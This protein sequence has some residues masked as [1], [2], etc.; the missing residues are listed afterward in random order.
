MA[1]KTDPR[2]GT[3]HG[4]NPQFLLEKLTRAK[5]YASPYWKEHCFG[6]T[7]E[8]LL[9]KA[10][11]IEYLGGCYGGTAKPTKFLCL[12]LKMLQLQPERE[13]VVELIKNGDF[14]YV[15]ALGAVYLRMVG[16]PEDVY[17]YLE[18]LLNDY[19]K[20]RVRE[21]VGWRLTN[22]DEFA[23]R[24]LREPYC[25]DLA[26]PHLPKRSVLEEQRRLRP[27]RSILE[28]EWEAEEASS[29]ATAQSP[30]PISSFPHDFNVS[31]KRA[32][33]ESRIGYGN[34]RSPDG[35]ISGRE[36]ESYQPDR[37]G[38]NDSTARHGQKKRKVRG[39]DLFKST[40][41]SS[42]STDIKQNKGATKA[43]EGS[44]EYWNEQR[45]KLGLQPLRGR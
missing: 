20:I 44:L 9:E 36:N 40:G 18:P 12:V 38:L 41:G 31:D 39:D 15:R 23:D 19:R 2:A 29:D 33:G 17:R 22:M 24:L 34:W 42:T 27:R 45:A 30:P 16:K 43:K 7:A 1:N 6:L 11:G 4:T 8:G 28:Q 35:S 13:I 32:E 3:V 25:F 10:V 5:I 37:S 26:L 21:G 14:K